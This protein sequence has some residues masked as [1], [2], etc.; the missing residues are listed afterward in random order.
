[1]TVIVRPLTEPS[2]ARDIVMIRLGG[3]AASPAL[4]AFETL[5]RRFV[6]QLA[7]SEVG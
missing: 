3:R 6:R 1:M 2:I 7:P 4:A 5:L